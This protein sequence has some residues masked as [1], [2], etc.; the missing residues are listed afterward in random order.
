MSL[1]VFQNYAKTADAD[2]LTLGLSV[3]S[4]MPNDPRFARPPV[5]LAELQKDLEKFS[6]A[7]VESLDGSKK[8]IAEKTKLRQEIIKWLRLLGHYVEAISNDDAAVMV[9]SGF[10]PATVTR[11][12]PQPL[13]T[14]AIRYI[15]HGVSGQSLVM[16]DGVAKARSYEIRY[17]ELSGGTAGSWSIQATTTVRSV[18]PINGLTPGTTYTFQVRALGRLGFTDWS[19]SV[20]CICT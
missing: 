15:D 13:P 8:V 4:K 16:I 17:A 14:P 20:N 12:T 9:S 1:K 11:S 18:T 6:K 7:I 10:Q 3:T 19:D 2:V 5:D